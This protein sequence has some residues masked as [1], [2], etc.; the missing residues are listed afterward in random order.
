MR[1]GQETPG[2]QIEQDPT[3]PCQQQGEQ[4]CL[5]G[6]KRLSIDAGKGCQSGENEHDSGGPNGLL[7]PE[8]DARNTRTVRYFVKRDAQGNRPPQMPASV[9]ALAYGKPVKK[10]VYHNARCTPDTGVG[11]MSMVR[12][13]L[14]WGLSMVREML[15][16][17]ETQKP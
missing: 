16:E 11:G 4:G 9:K 14:G 3:E 10:T 1:C 7:R 15:N 12:G 17:I 13:L 5:K 2:S 6:H 8:H